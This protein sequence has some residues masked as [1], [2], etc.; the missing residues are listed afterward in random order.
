MTAP[1]R[2]SAT[3]K[4]RQQVSQRRAKYQSS[5]SR[6]DGGILA[7]LKEHF[8]IENPPLPL[9]FQIGMNLSKAC[10]VKFPRDERRRRELLIGWLNHNYDTFKACI[11]KMV[12]RDEEGNYSGPFRESWES[13]RANNPDEPVVKYLQGEQLKDDGMAM[14]EQ[15]ADVK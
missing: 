13:F 14:E 7:D 3:E 2:L 4:D 10:N 5:T 15:K 6:T 12:I 8:G 1:P 11:P 9:L